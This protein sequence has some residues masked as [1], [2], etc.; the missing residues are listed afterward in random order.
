MNEYLAIAQ[1]LIHERSLG[2]R[3]FWAPYMGVL[4][5]TEE[6]GPTFVWPES[7]FAMLEGSPVVN[8]TLSMRAKLRA[9][10]EAVLA[11]AAARGAPLEPDVFTYEAWEWAFTMLFSRAI[12]LR[13][14]TGGETLAMVPYA[15]LINHSPYSAAY[16]DARKGERPLPWAEREDD[17]VI[18]YA[19]RAYKKF[20]QLYIS[21]GQKSNAELLLLYG[22]AL[23]RNPFNSVALSVGVSSDD[24]L[25]EAKAQFASLAGRTAA[26]TAFPLFL[27]R[28]PDELFQFL[29][30][31]CATEK[32]LVAA[33]AVN[34]ARTGVRPASSSARALLSDADYSRRL[35]NDN[36]IEVLTT[37]ATAC[38]AALDRYPTSE[39][40]DTK[41][42]DDRTMFNMLSRNQRMAIRLRRTEKRLLKKTI[43]TTGRRLAEIDGPVAAKPAEDFNRVVT[44]PG[45]KGGVEML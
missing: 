12:R 7:E 3:S 37:I 19:D 32:D 17:D 15:D 16:V 36:E 14:A 30:M 10:H 28:F 31:A 5:T 33:A 41:L 11:S 27:D 20:E 13:S 23:D 24:P 43:E 42:I 6:V 25:Y 39:E 1:L 9:E 34:A 29:R 45:L 8:A 38:D 21:Y 44:F 40:E 22:F 26:A 2:D 35:S 4:P 18:L